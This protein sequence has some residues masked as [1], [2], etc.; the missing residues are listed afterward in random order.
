MTHEGALTTIF[1]NCSLLIR[2]IDTGQAVSFFALL[3]I[4]HSLAL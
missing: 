3:L 1:A 2:G 4:A